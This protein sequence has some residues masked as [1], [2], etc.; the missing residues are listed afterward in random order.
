MYNLNDPHEYAKQAKTDGLSA[1]DLEMKLRKAGY[2]PY[3]R[4]ADLTL[5]RFMV[6]NRP[7]RTPRSK[8]PTRPTTKTFGG[9][10]VVDNSP[11]FKK[12]EE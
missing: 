3:T 9:R 12:V 2:P 6:I 5:R 10:Y 11:K 1:Y 4:F 8:K 7:R